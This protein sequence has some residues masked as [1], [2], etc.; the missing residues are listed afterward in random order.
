MQEEA[1]TG[2]RGTD[3]RAMRERCLQRCREMNIPVT[4]AMTVTAG[5]LPFLWEAVAFGLKLPNVRGICF[6]PEFGSG[7]TANSGSVRFNTADIILAAVGQS[8]NDFASK[9]SRRCRAAIPIA[10]RSATCSKSMGG[11]RSVSDFIDFTTCR[12]FFATKSATA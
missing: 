3:L 10:R 8:S 11:M 9:I 5:N 4:L 7:R 6:Q 1:Q 12:V 2:L